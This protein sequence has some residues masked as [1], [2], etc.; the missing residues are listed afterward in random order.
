MRFFQLV[1]L[2]FLLVFLLFQGGGCG[3]LLGE[4]CKPERRC[5]RCG[6]GCGDCRG[7]DSGDGVGV[8]IDIGDGGLPLVVVASVALAPLPL[9]WRSAGGGALRGGPSAAGVLLRGRSAGGGALRGGPGGAFV[10]VS[11]ADFGAVCHD[12]SGG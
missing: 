1:S 10:K 3:T 9:P 4:G 7:E 11:A 2:T 5:G 8:A 6:E 12:T